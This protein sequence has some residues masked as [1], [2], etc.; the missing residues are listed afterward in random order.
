MES[1][2]AEL[3]QLFP[4]TDHKRLRYKNVEHLQDFCNNKNNEIQQI[5]SAG[6]ES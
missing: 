5:Y 2:G 1:N 6:M 3:M 4:E